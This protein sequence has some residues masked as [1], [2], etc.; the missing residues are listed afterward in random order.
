V[1]LGAFAVL[2]AL[3]AV[4]AYRLIE[5]PG[6][7]LGARLALRLRRAPAALPA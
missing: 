6:I 1:K 2:Q 3:V 5:A 4:A 7:R